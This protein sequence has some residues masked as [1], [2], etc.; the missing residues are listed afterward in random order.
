M[1]LLPMIEKLERTNG[2]EQLKR[3]IESI[4]D[5]LAVD[6]KDRIRKNNS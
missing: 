2:N 3:I 6:I 1:T 5:N 4:T